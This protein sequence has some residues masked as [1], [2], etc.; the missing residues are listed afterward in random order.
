MPSNYGKIKRCSI[1]QDNKSFKRNINIYVVSQANNGTLV[2]ANSILKS[3]LKTWIS[4]YKMINDTIDILDAKIINYGIDFNI[5][6]DSLYDKTDILNKALNALYT[7][8]TIKDIGESISVAEIY[9][10]L[11]KITGVIDVTSVRIVPKIGGSYSDTYINFD[12]ATTYDGKYVNAPKN[13]IFE[14]KFPT[15]DIKGTVS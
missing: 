1:F 6:V 12:K 9:N 2:T 3:N 14:I 15:L 8:V 7:Q 13:A 11:N 10:I 5:I 4:Q